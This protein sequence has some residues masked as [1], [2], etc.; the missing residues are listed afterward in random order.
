MIS[1]AGANNTVNNYQLADFT[2][3][4]Q[5]PSKKPQLRIIIPEEEDNVGIHQ[6]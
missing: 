4:E 3:A 5:L 6:S 2:M 1:L